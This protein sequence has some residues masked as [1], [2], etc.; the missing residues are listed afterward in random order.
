MLHLPFGVRVR[1]WVLPSGFWAALALLSGCVSLPP[2][3]APTSEADRLQRFEETRTNTTLLNEGMARILAHCRSHFR[4]LDQE[5]QAWSLRQKDPLSGEKKLLPAAIVLG[6][7]AI[8]LN[9]STEAYLFSHGV[10][11]VEA[12]VMSTLEAQRSAGEHMA[13]QASDVTGQAQFSKE[14]VTHYLQTMENQ[15]QPDRIRTTLI[16]AVSPEQ[17]LPNIA[18]VLLPDGPL[19]RSRSRATMGGE[20]TLN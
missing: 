1:A 16:R 12:M 3:D 13:Q 5:A 4:E 20:R 11:G 2:M 7:D 19:K 18:P 6:F 9:R 14:Q 8:T 10:K 15:C 17:T